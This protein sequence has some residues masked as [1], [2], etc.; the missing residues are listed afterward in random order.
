MTGCPRFF[1]SLV[2]LNVVLCSLAA[3]EEDPARV[4]TLVKYDYVM[5]LLN[6]GGSE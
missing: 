3:G 1:A 6:P 5:E 4:K 2:L